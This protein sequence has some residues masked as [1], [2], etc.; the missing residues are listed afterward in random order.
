MENL[1]HFEQ[2]EVPVAK[3]KPREIAENLW[4]CFFE[5]GYYYTW[6]LQIFITRSILRLEEQPWYQKKGQNLCILKYTICKISNFQ[7]K[8][9]SVAVAGH[10]Y[11]LQF[12]STPLPVYVSHCTLH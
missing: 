4:T 9:H 7:L 5:N 3:E 10:K 8:T 11:A 1:V 6:T 12:S 2:L